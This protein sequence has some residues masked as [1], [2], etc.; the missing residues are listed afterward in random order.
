MDKKEK[1]EILSFLRQKRIFDLVKFILFV[2]IFVNIFGFYQDYKEQE[3]IKRQ[4]E[5][6][7][8]KKK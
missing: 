4:Q 7:I 3:E 1:K 6:L 5:V 8:A 2:L